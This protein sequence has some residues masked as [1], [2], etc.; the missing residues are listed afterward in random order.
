MSETTKVF[1]LA[2]LEKNALVTNF[3]DGQQAA[4]DSRARFVAVLAGTQSGKTSFTPFWMAEEMLRCGPGDYLVVAPTFQLLEKKLLPE[5]V[6]LFEKWLGVGRYYAS[7]SRQFVF[8]EDGARKMF[9]EK[10]DARRDDLPRIL[11]GYATDPESLESATAK[12]AVC[13]EAGQKKFKLGSV[14]AIQRRLSLAAGGVIEGFPTGRILFTT[15]LYALNW[16]KD[17]Y[18]AWLLAAKNHDATDWEFVNFASVANPVFPREEYARARRDLPRWKFLMQYEG[19][20]ERPAGQVYDCLD[21]ARHFIPRTALP[22]DWRRYIG[23]DFGEVNTAAVVVAEDPRTRRRIVEHEYKPGRQTVR[24]HVANL[25]RLAPD[26]LYAVGG[27]KSEDE[28]RQDFRRAGL[29]VR[30]PPVWELDVGIQRTYAEFS[31]DR[32]QV[33]ED[34]AQLKDELGSYGFV[35]DEHDAP[36]DEIEDKSEYHL[37][38]ALRYVISQLAQKSETFATTAQVRMEW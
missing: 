18:D 22:H 19:K 36:T 26:A 15:S 14:E 38:D 35:L 24:E 30:E 37:C 23:I 11:F 12:A 2:R 32:L 20:F 4:L 10:Y 34:C 6:R 33:F 31:N 21:R 16:L 17:K 9:G 3:H 8:N 27:A 7:P 1:P 25:K 13:D 28:W 29:A 5:F